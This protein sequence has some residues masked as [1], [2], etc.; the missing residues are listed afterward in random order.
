LASAQRIGDAAV[1]ILR[2]LA[3]NPCGYSLFA[4]LRL[5]EESFPE[6]PRLGDASRPAE[7][8]VRVS[9][10]PHLQFAP[11]DVCKFDATSSPRPTLQAYSF[12]LF[13]PNGALPLHITEVAFTRSLQQHDSGVADFINLFNHRFATLFFRAW[14]DSDPTTSA[15]RP[16]VDPYRENLAAL[17]GIASPA[18]QSRGV[19]PDEA[20]FSRADLFSAQ[21]RSADRLAALLSEYFGVP[22]RVREFVGQWLDIP[23]EEQ[24]CLGQ[25]VSALG[26]GA[27]LGATSWQRQNKFE[28]VLGPLSLI[29]FRKY[30]PTGSALYELIDLVCF[31][32]HDEWAWQLRLELREKDV[33]GIKLGCRLGN[34]A[35]LGWSSWL[36]VRSET[37]SDV[38]IQHVVGVKR[39]A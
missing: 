10:P 3:D 15:D 36:G 28:I 30:L 20:K 24:L 4:A 34:G 13:G 18:A 16:G 1:T 27:S 39:H 31:F 25:T 35:Q 23:R 38:V 33:P 6:A 14:A 12:G 17:T 5:I 7:E 11:T 2:K 8:A 22:I 21:V 19:V 29:E 9:Q 26:C 37:A 32:T